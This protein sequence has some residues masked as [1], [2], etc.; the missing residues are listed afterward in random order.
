MYKSNLFQA[1]IAAALR[2]DPFVE[3]HHLWDARDR[4]IMGPA[5]RRPLDDQTN[6]VSA[7]HEA[8]HALVALL[9]AE[10]IPLHKVCRLIFYLNVISFYST[11]SL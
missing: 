6:R 11:L 2:N 1:A 10:S 5:K 8:G 9:T 4:L 3:M 7:F